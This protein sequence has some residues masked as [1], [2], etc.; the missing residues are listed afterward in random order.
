MAGLIGA[1][2]NVG[3]LLVG[4][5]GLGLLDVLANFGRR[6]LRRIG[7][8][9][10]WVSCSLPMMAGGDDAPGNACRPF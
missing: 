3:Y 7:L 4:F 8:P 10:D 5:V 9:E 1:A 6:M 2:A